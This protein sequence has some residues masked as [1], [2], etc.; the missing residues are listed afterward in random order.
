MLRKETIVIGSKEE[1]LEYFRA[2]RCKDVS[3]TLTIAGQL[4]LLL[5]EGGPFR[6]ISPRINRLSAG[7]VFILRELPEHNTVAGM[8]TAELLF[9]SSYVHVFSKEE[10][11]RRE[12][13]R[14]ELSA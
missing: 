8:Q 2:E 11:V 4:D 13:L 10:A 9:T 5:L 12:K 6:A 3:S 14:E 1:I 7:L